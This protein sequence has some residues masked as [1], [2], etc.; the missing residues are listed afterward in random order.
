MWNGTAMGPSP[1][2]VARRLD[3]VVAGR[4]DSLE[5][6]GG[7]GSA[8]SLVGPEADVVEESQGEPLL[9]VVEG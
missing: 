5:R 9:Q 3:G 4:L 2:P 6:L 1:G 7:R 8:Q